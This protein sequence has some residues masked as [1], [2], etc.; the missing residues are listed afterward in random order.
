MCGR[1][2]CGIQVTSLSNQTASRQ[3]SKRTFLNRRLSE[4]SLLNRQVSERSGGDD[5][6]FPHEVQELFDWLVALREDLQDPVLVLRLG[7]G[8]WGLRFGI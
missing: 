1:G 3:L 5:D 8:V 4:R 2:L 7:F 6:L